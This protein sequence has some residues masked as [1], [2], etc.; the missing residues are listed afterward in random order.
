MGMITESDN[1]I[2]SSG[3]VRLRLKEEAKVLGF[4][5]EY[6]FIALSTVEVGYYSAMRRTVIASTIPHLRED[7]LKDMEIPVQ[8]KEHIDKITTLVS[9]AFSLKAK[10]KQI[11]KESDAI[12][13]RKL[14]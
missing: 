13:N 14:F 4:T 1:V 10:R 7:R 5:Q 12:Y 2:L 3:I 6:L 8:D 9:E 11:L